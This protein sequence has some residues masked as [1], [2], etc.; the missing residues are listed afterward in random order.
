MSA[1]RIALIS[2][3]HTL[4]LGRGN[5]GSVTILEMSYWLQFAGSVVSLRQHGVG[6]KTRCA[7]PRCRKD[8]VY[9]LLPV[10]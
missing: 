2:P 7:M 3:L 1:K 6:E 5:A 8:T 9:V 10:S 4:S